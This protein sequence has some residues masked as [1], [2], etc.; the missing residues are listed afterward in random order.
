VIEEGWGFWWVDVRIRW[1]LRISAA[2]GVLRRLAL[3]VSLRRHFVDQ[4]SKKDVD[5][6]LSF[7]TLDEV[8]DAIPSFGAERE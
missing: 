3:V 5:V 8:A 7:A 1:L 6:A 2:L 4:S